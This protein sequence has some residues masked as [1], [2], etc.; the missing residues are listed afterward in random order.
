MNS[1]TENPL[2]TK[3]HTEIRSRIISKFPEIAGCSHDN[4]LFL[5]KY[6][7]TAPSNLYQQTTYK[8]IVKWFLDRDDSDQSDLQDYLREHSVDISR[9]LMHL[10]EIN[11]LPWYDDPLSDKDIERIRFIDRSV[12]PSY[13]RL[14]EGV[15]APLLHCIAYFSR[16]DRGKNTDGLDIWN[17][18]EEVKR[19]SLKDTT[20][21]YINI[22][23]NG[24]AHGGIMY[25]EREIKYHDKKGNEETY[26]TSDMIRLFDDLLDTCNAVAAAIGVFLL[27]K[28]TEGYRLP[29]H[30]LFEELRARTKTPYWIVDACISASSIG[31][32]QLI[33]YIRTNTRDYNKVQLSAF[34]TGILAG[35][36][37]PGYQRYFISIQSDKALPG[38]AAFNGDKIANLV[39]QGNFTIQDC[40]DVLEEGLVFYMPRPKLPK[41]L[42][43]INTFYTAAKLNI[44]LAV[45]E[46]RKNMGKAVIDVRNVSI[47]RNGWRLVL[48]GQIVIH[49]TSNSINRDDIYK[50]LHRIIK[51]AA[52][53]ARSKKPFFG[54]LRH[55]PLG[56]VYLSIFNQNY[57]KRRLAGYGLGSDLVCTLRVQKIK[58]IKVPD[59]M[60]STIEER[61]K[62]RIAWNKSWLESVVV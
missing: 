8:H 42:S 3:L 11:S 54:F 2:L 24:I 18:V 43:T 19:G 7:D 16:K 55:L 56:F 38:W 50:S 40:G 22:I 51:M 53:K 58:R 32:N 35:V 28:L 25:H 45:A 41:I 37:S 30:V 21:A 29:Q 31:G 36:L 46:F 47:H 57:R 5:H 48:K 15:F 49:P 27:S 4:I 59:I 34:Q 12:H 14:T 6:L 26:D 17:I 20:E 13:L 62:Y 39:S 9:A 23:R 61:G 44:P 52:K 10:D 60:G 33:V 1:V